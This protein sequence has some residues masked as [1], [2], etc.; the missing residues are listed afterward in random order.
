M[1]IVCLADNSYEMSSHMWI[2]SHEMS[3][4]IF[5]KRK[6]IFEYCQPRFKVLIV[7]YNG[8]TKWNFFGY[9]QIL[10]TTI[11]LHCMHLQSLI[12]GFAICLE[13]DGRL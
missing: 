9:M 5:S 12:M 3:S 11:S 2:N 7:Y 6:S 4:L 8:H 13:Y 10:K 1:W